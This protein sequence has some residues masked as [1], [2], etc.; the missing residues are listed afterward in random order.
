M[1]YKDNSPSA[2]GKATV[3]KYQSGSWKTLGSEGVSADT[4]GYLDLALDASGN[5]FL[6]YKDN[7]PSVGGKAT[8]IVFR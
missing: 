6:A 7:A 1:A 5:V 2:A 8:V 3:K 4:V